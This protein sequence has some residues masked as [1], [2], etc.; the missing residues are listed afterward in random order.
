VIAIG[1]VNLVKCETVPFDSVPSDLEVEN[2]SSIEYQF[3][4]LLAGVRAV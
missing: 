1:E 2:A 4:I 3:I